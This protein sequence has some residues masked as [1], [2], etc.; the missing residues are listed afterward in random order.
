MGTRKEEKDSRGK[1]RGKRRGGKDASKKKVSSGKKSEKELGKEGVK[2][3]LQSFYNHEAKKYYETRK[4]FWKEGELLLEEMDSFEGKKVSILEFGC[5]SGRFA[6]FLRER[7]S[8]KFSYVGVDL[9]EGLLSYAQKENP[10]L[11]FICEDI[12]EFVVKQ[13]QESFDIIIGTS[14]F[15]HIPSF[16]ERLFLMK[17]FYRLLKYDGK[18]IMTNWSL[19]HRFIKKHWGE[20][21]KAMGRYVLSFGK[22]SRRDILVPWT[23]KGQ[24]FKRYYHLFDLKE[25]KRLSDFSGLNLE[26][27]CYLDN[28]GKKSK[29]WKSSRSS[30]FVAKKSP[31][32]EEKD[33]EH[34]KKC[35]I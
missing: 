18:V 31:I 2:A 1:T 12:S 3:D 16:K 27:L 17:H 25:L 6:S 32:V 11:T 8:G 35:T 14:S 15:Q 30:L 5:G 34:M 9:S 22:A 28:E 24:T 10:K 33:S 21:A 7:Y 13:K 20:I 23:N 19:S 26:E 29:E 4:K